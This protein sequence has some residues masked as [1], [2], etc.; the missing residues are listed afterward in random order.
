VPGG[1]RRTD[2]GIASS[3]RLA[4]HRRCNVTDHT[5][6][7]ETPDPSATSLP[8]YGRASLSVLAEALDG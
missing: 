6:R 5:R 3:F 2:I 8:F 4:I 1:I 7:G